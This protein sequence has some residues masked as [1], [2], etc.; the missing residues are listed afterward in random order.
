MADAL[1]GYAGSAG[2]DRIDAAP[3][4]GDRDLHEDEFR[5]PVFRGTAD[6]FISYEE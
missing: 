2:T 6:Y 1:D 3:L 4:E 5:K